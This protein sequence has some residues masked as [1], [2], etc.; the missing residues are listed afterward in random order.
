MKFLCQPIETKLNDPRWYGVDQTPKIIEAEN[1]EDCYKIL[2]RD[3]G[4]TVQKISP[5]KYTTRVS[6]WSRKDL[7][8]CLI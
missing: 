5:N 8:E 6:P 3:H 2:T 7:V 1:Q 4:L